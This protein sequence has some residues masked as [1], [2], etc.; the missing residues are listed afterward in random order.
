M[1]FYKYKFINIFILL[2]LITSHSFAV[3]VLREVKK[4]ENDV[5]LQFD[6][7][8][9]SRDVKVEYLRDII[10]ISISQTNVYPA[11]I[12]SFDNGDIKKIFAYQYSPQ[13]IRV[14]LTVDG[15]AE[16]YKKR[17]N[18]KVNKNKIVASIAEVPN[19]VVQPE[20]KIL[21][22][23]A[24]EVKSIGKKEDVKTSPLLAKSS[25]N[26]LSM[27]E[28]FT[29]VLIKLGVFVF[30]ILGAAV[31]YKKI[32]TK[33]KAKGNFKRESRFSGVIGKFFKHK[34]L[35][36][37]PFMEVLAT[38]HLAPKKSI[39]V[40]KIKNET[41]VLGVSDES[42]NLITKMKKEESFEVGHQKEDTE[43]FNDLLEE[44]VKSNHSNAPIVNSITHSMISSD[45]RDK[46]RK[47]IGEMKII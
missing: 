2:F 14:R 4:N 28:Q 20:K 43:N 24:N 32:S 25:E 22:G 35:S 42:I 26:E 6:K 19:V 23:E 27:K 3:S 11:K 37:E 46:I 31:F 21:K 12:M 7:E 36:T 29:K 15:D 8:M 40:V 41:L 5:Q 39:M 1:N 45:V 38:H 16:N 9:Y 33:N 18:F 17:F 30:I 13:L 10:Q 44:E 34:F 47:K